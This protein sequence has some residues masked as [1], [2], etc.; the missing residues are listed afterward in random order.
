MAHSGAESAHSSD[1]VGCGYGNAFWMFS[2][3]CHALQATLDEATAIWLCCLLPGSL[4]GLGA[5]VA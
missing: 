2:S 1:P 3:G 4:D 5:H